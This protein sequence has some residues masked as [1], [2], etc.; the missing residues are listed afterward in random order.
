MKSLNE[1][2]PIRSNA[3]GR[4]PFSKLAAESRVAGS[5]RRAE[6]CRPPPF[7]RIEFCDGILV[8]I[9]SDRRADNAPIAFFRFAMDQS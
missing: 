7:H 5:I 2:G 8:S 3:P 4:C 6:P 1:A 9:Q